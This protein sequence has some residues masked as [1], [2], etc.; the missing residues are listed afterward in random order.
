MPRLDAKQ[1]ACRGA[2]FGSGDFPR[3]LRGDLSSIAALIRPVVPSSIVL[4]A[5]IFM[6][7]NGRARTRSFSGYVPR[8]RPSL[9][10]IS[11]RR[12]A[13]RCGPEATKDKR[14][15]LTAPF[16]SSPAPSEAYHRAQLSPQTNVR[17]PLRIQVSG[18]ALRIAR[19]LSRHNRSWCLFLY[20]SGEGS[21][22][23]RGS[24]AA[25]LGR[26]TEKVVPLQEP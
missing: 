16:V 1:K 10:C 25:S 23:L 13:S 12:P 6:R 24:G 2:L 20:G 3:I 19:G 18:A 26:R 5:V 8:V 14:P 17:L 4:T 11:I 15:T 7:A 22:A 9:I 21:H